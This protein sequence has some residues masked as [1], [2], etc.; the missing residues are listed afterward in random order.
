MQQRQRPDLG[1][2]ASTNT[3]YGVQFQGQYEARG[4]G[5][6]SHEFSLGVR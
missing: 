2:N 3:D 6:A 1:V 4:F 5:T